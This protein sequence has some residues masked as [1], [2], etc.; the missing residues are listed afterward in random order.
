MLYFPFCN[1]VEVCALALGIAW[2]LW[3]PKWLASMANALTWCALHCNSTTSVPQD[4]RELHWFNYDFPLF[5]HSQWVSLFSDF[6]HRSCGPADSHEREVTQGRLRWLF[7]VWLSQFGQNDCTCKE[8][9][10][11]GRGV[12]LTVHQALLPVVTSHLSS[13]FSSAQPK[14][15]SYTRAVQWSYSCSVPLRVVVEIGGYH[16][17]SSCRL[18]F[19]LLHHA[20]ESHP[21]ID[22]SLTAS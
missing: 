8:E 4:P 10:L 17:L 14:A 12:T 22:F 9:E 13:N 3:Q 1:S 6:A 5:M 16:R 2:L 21:S 18:H 19:Q 7:W 20:V 11:S 15:R